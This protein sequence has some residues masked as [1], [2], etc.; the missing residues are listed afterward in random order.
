MNGSPDSF[1]SQLRAS[2]Q[3][4]RA[5]RQL[6]AEPALWPGARL[7]S[8]GRGRSPE[9]GRCAGPGVCPGRGSPGQ[10]GLML[11]TLQDEPPLLMASA[12]EQRPPAFSGWPAGLCLAGGTGRPLSGTQAGPAGQRWAGQAGQ[13][14]C[15]GRSGQAGPGMASGR[16]AAGPGPGQ[17]ASTRPAR[18]ATCPWAGATWT[19]QP[20][21]WS[22]ASP[23]RRGLAASRPNPRAP[24]PGRPAAARA[25]LRWPGLSCSLQERRLGA[26]L[27]AARGRA[28]G[29][30]A[31]R[32]R[33]RRRP[34]CPGPASHS[35]WNVTT[36]CREYCDADTLSLSLQPKISRGQDA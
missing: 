3:L 21:A 9:Q 12:G 27:L 34:L 14:C 31:W 20:Y 23:N 17:G 4:E 1:T 25:G 18:G 26:A 16:A 5:S 19:G 8:G 10:A 15:W 13:G 6:L 24:E 7:E 11:E 36:W 32:A 22:E 28:R 29:R 2:L 30:A 33:A 35:F